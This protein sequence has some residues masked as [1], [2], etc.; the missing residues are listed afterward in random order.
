M[1]PTFDVT[2]NMYYSI[3]KQTNL[4]GKKVY[5]MKNIL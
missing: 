4:V 5:K 2:Y 1:K 3:E